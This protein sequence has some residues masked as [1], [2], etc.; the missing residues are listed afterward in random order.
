MSIMVTVQLPLEEVDSVVQALHRASRTYYHGD[1]AQRACL[2]A[3]AQFGSAAF[4]V[5]EKPLAEQ[6]TMPEKVAG[7]PATGSGI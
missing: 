4:L 6:I 7:I 2:H 5:K 1:P 3:A